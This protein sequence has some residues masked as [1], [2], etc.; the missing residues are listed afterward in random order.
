MTDEVE[1]LVLEH[2]KRIQA[3]LARVRQL[4]DLAMR[5]LTV[6]PNDFGKPKR[7]R[8]QHASPGHNLVRGR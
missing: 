1:N 8:P 4:Q 5:R 2:L 3:E 7:E 6:A